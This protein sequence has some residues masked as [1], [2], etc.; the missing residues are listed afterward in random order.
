[1]IEFLQNKQERI[2]SPE[3]LAQGVSVLMTKP[4]NTDTKA[5]LLLFLKNNDIKAKVFR[6]TL[7]EEM[8]RKLYPGIQQRPELVKATNEH[9]AGKEV[10]VFLVSRDEGN[11]S[12]KSVLDQ[13]AELVG[14]KTDPQANEGGTLRKSF[15]GR[16]T[17]RDESG[18]PIRYFENGFHRPTTSVE[19]VE[20]LDALGLLDE[21]RRIIRTG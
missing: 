18:K 9:M 8:L 16:R 11:T 15:P 14:V 6:F 17:Y 1:M 4:E 7:D 20:Q 13:V 5:P 10:E 2:I 19:L 3:E 12:E 21:A